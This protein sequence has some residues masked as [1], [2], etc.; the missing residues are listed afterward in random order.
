MLGQLLGRHKY[1]VRNFGL[2]GAT[3][4]KKGNI[5]YWGTPTMIKAKQFEPDHVIIMFGANAAKDV[6]FLHVAEFAHDLH[7]M[8]DYFKQIPSLPKDGQFPDG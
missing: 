1:E 7:A 8:V 5:T 2:P 4:L 3:V 6:N